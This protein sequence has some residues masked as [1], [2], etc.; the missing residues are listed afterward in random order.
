MSV[1]LG[2]AA[3]HWCGLRCSA[4]LGISD[5][6]QQQPLTVFDYSR[7]IRASMSSGG[8]ADLTAGKKAAAYRAVDECVKVVKQSGFCL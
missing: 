6:Q 2:R 3:R 1:L 7:K 4:V 5:T 8:G